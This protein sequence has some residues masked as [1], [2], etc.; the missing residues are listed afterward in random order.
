[1]NDLRTVQI[2][3]KS[4]SDD[5]LAEL[6]FGQGVSITALRVEQEG[7]GIEIIKYNSVDLHFKP[8]KHLRQFEIETRE[9]DEKIIV[10]IIANT[11][12][13]CIWY[14]PDGRDK[15]I[16]IAP[17]SDNITYSYSRHSHE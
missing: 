10:N 17:K 16:Y 14:H 11:K 3:C 4:N 1:M 13:L 2:L 12:D 7:E 6:T 8:L 15:P 9:E 5:Q